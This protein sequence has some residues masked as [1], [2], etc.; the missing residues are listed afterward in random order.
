MNRKKLRDFQNE[1]LEKKLNRHDRSQIF[2]LNLSSEREFEPTLISP[3]RISID[4]NRFF[5]NH[6]CRTLNERESFSVRFVWK[7][8]VDVG[9][10]RTVRKCFS[11]FERWTMKIFDWN[12]SIWSWSSRRNRAHRREN[13]SSSTRNRSIR[14]DGFFC[15]VF[16]RVQRPSIEK[17]FL[18]FS[19][20][21]S[22]RKRT[23]VTNNFT[24]PTVRKLNV[25]KGSSFSLSDRKRENLVHCR[26]EWRN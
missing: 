3:S 6:R 7:G 10:V 25:N 4:A 2:E 26:R 13:C 24:S 23:I 22:N 8:R 17:S 1:R 12:V 11:D 15:S 5:H 18:F 20:E 9:F 16:R 14:F 19:I 21:V